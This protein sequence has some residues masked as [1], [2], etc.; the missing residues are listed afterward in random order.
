MYKTS[1][2]I[3]DVILSKHIAIFIVKMIVNVVS[4]KDHALMTVSTSMKE[5]ERYAATKLLCHQQE[6][7]DKIFDA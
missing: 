3:F 4:F 1:S 2:S 7:P 5:R 6:M